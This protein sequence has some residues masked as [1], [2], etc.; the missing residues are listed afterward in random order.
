MTSSNLE[1][2]RE[3][4]VLNNLFYN[5]KLNANSSIDS[6]LYGNKSRFI[7]HSKKASNSVPRKFSIREEE[8]IIFYALKNI[9]QGEE[10]LFN[11]NGE[12][13]LNEFTDKYPFIDS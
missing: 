11:Y 8:I 3:N 7:N 12:G 10:I 4:L 5:F 1:K 9:Y 6:R 2:L 13:S